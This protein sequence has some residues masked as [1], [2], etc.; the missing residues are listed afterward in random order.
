[1][2][3]RPPQV[4]GRRDDD[5]HDNTRIIDAMTVLHRVRSIAHAIGTLPGRCFPA[6]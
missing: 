1:M 5:N 3:M 4:A 2:M 6:D